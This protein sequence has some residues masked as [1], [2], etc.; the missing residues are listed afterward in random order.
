VLTFE[1]GMLIK[2]PNYVHLYMLII[3]RLAAGQYKIL[4]QHWYSTLELWRKHSQSRRGTHW[5]TF[6]V[7]T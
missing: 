6:Y 5:T 2:R 1:L 3:W 4:E 7:V